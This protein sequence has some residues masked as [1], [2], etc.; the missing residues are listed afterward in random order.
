MLSVERGS[1]GAHRPGP[2]QGRPAQVPVAR[3]LDPLALG[4]VATLAGLGLANLA[5]LGD[6]SVTQHQLVVDAA[7]VALFVTL[8]RWRSDGLRW[9]GWGCYLLSL[10]LLMAVGGSA[11]DWAGPAGRTVAGDIEPAVRRTGGDRPPD[12][13]GVLSSSPGSGDRA[14]TVRGGRSS[15]G[16]P[17]GSSPQ[18]LDDQ[19]RELQR[20]LR[21]PARV[22]GRLVAVAEL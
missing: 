2:Q 18:H 20:L 11:A 12:G 5:A 3:L 22:A 4:A 10:L 13:M 19:E 8:L 14:G 21:V 16:A 9:V 6:R 15:A 17:V 7:G 1:R